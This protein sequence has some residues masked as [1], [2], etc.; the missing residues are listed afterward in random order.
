MQQLVAAANNMSLGPSPQPPPLSR[1]PPLPSVTPPLPSHT[2]P[3]QSH[4]PPIPTGTP[5]TMAANA[6]AYAA[7]M[8]AG[9]PNLQQTGFVNPG[10]MHSMEYQAAYQVD[11][12]LQSSVAY[13]KS[14]L[15]SGTR[16]N[17]ALC[18]IYHLSQIPHRNA[19]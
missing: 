18:K 1:T 10:M 16:K 17:D 6:A 12:S 19:Q 7:A 15:V 3:L 11:S 2:P 14:P 8:A 5:Q 13:W 9:Q 4:T